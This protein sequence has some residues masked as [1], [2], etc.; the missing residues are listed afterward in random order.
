MY[1]CIHVNQ[2]FIWNNVV[3]MTYGAWSPLFYNKKTLI[4]TVV[5]FGCNLLMFV[6]YDVEKS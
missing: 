3:L 2:L 5:L 1:F 4:N 6:Q